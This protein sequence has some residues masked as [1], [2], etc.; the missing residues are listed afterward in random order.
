MSIKEQIVDILLDIKPDAEEDC[1][2]LIDDGVL[3]SFDIISLIGELKD[4]F[5]INITA[6][7]II[8]D[9]FNSVAA[10]TEMVERLMEG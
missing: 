1:I 8:P 3:D 7:D 6:A 9:N 10:L 5:D 2:S 4:T